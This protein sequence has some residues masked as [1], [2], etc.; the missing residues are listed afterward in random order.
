MNYLEYL[1]TT[2]LGGVLILSGAWGCVSPPPVDAKAK[3]PSSP[4]AAVSTP[5]IKPST[6]ITYVVTQT[7]PTL[8]EQF[9]K[10][11][12]LIHQQNQNLDRLCVDVQ[13]ALKTLKA[14][15]KP[16][17]ATP[18]NKPSKSP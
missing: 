4:D 11:R 16:G 10:Q 2:V 17:K 18:A 12:K 3:A 14:K 9:Q 15:K 1:Q 6:R 5:P 13:K 8:Q 7:K